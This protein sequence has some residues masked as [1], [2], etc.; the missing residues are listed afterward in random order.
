MADG[1]VNLPSAKV[2]S[3]PEAKDVTP[4]AAPAPTIMPPLSQAGVDLANVLLIMIAVFVVIAVIWIWMAES[5]YSNW[6]GQTHPH[7]AGDPT[8]DSM[9]SAEGSFREFWLKIFQMVLL[10]V[11]L[12]VLTAILGYT[13]GSSQTGKQ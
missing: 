5:S 2:V 9:A 8:L 13:F 4:P 6:L 11:L 3:L 12:P 1:N 10:N 7:G